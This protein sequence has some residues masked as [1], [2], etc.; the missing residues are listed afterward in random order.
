MKRKK[1]FFIIPAAMVGIALF[2]TFG[3]WVVMSLWN[4][5]LPGLF[6]WRL[7]TFW[8]A[9]AMLVLCRILVGGLGGGSNGSKARRRSGQRWECMTPE[10]HDRFREWMRSRRGDLGASPAGTPGTA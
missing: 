7:I 6:G 2:M 10:E 3:G 8:Q 1:L 9:M 4:W 5:L